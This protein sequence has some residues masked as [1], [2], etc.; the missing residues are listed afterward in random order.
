ML[1]TL[2]RLGPTERAEQALAELSADERASAQLRIAAAALRLAAGDPQAAA[3]A[4]AP[5]V[6]GP[7]SGVLRVQTVT[8]LLLAARARDALGDQAAAGRALEQALAVTAA[9]GI[10]LPFL[11]DGDPALLTPSCSPRSWTCCGGR[12]GPCR[13]ATAQ[14]AGPCAAA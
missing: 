4:L 11:L 12:P 6:D 8:A 3:D 1:Q 14:H 5:V 10:L 9:N 13:R 2:A 7:V